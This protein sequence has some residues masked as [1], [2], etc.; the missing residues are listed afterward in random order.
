MSERIESY[1]DLNVYHLAFELQQDIFVISKSFP[2]DEKFSLI[3]QI[4]RSSRSIG[5]NLA[6]AWQKRRYIAHFINKLTDSD[7]ENAETEH[8]I[9]TSYACKYITKEQKDELISKCTDIG[10]MLGSMI[11]DSERFCKLRS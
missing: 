2:V 11:S 8:W 5:A 6:E 7:G 10:K 1:R 3:D 9:E 4:R